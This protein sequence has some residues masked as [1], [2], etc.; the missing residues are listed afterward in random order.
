MLGWR[1]TDHKPTRNAYVQRTIA[2]AL[3]FGGLMGTYAS[4]AATLTGWAASGLPS[5]VYYLGSIVAGA[6]LLGG[7][8]WARRMAVVVI[9]PETLAFTV[10]GLRAFM[11][12][13]WA[14]YVGIDRGTI[15]FWGDLG[16]G[17]VFGRAAGFTLQVNV[18][19]CVSI[20]WLLTS[21]SPR[22]HSVT[23][24]DELTTPTP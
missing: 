1:L 18:V 16:S 3:V 8:G 21:M 11:Y 15:G 17:Y 19:A 20:G 5:V 7:W 4:V 13:G 23:P 2:L 10:G 14:L 9:V 6:G 22:A 12:S 24:R